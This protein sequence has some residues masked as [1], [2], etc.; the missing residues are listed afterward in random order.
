[1]ADKK[2]HGAVTVS[3]KLQDVTESLEILAQVD[4]HP[5]TSVSLCGH[6]RSVKPSHPSPSVSR[7]QS[8]G[9]SRAEKQPDV[10]YFFA[11]LVYYAARVVRQYP[12]MCQCVRVLTDTCTSVSSLSPLPLTPSGG[13]VVL[14]CGRRLFVCKP[15]LKRFKVDKSSRPPGCEP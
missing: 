4:D 3:A 10:I 6:S 2:F 8:D 15:S 12:S 11:L 9:S 14:P 5:F 1:M 13:A 7:L